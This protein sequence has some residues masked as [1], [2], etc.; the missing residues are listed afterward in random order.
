[1]VLRSQRARDARL[2]SLAYFETEVSFEAGSPVGVPCPLRI[3]FGPLPRQPRAAQR[4]AC[5]S[6]ARPRPERISRRLGRSRL[7]WRRSQERRLF[8]SSDCGRHLG[9]DPRGVGAMSRVVMRLVL[10]TC[11]GFQL[12]AVCGSGI[13]VPSKH[14]RQ[15]SPTPMFRQAVADALVPEPP[16]R[17]EQSARRDH[18]DRRKYQQSNASDGS[19]R[20]VA[21]LKSIHISPRAPRAHL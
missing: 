9:D 14:A 19:R 10:P 17:L 21:S 8:R 7:S 12:A 2:A 1:M 15:P 5:P 4:P 13:R 11:R 16:A 3:H 20:M 6:A 18:S